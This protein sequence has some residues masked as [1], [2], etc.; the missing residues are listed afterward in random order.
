MKPSASPPSTASTPARRTVVRYLSLVMFVTLAAASLTA[1]MISRRTIRDQEQRV[2]AIRADEVAG[3]VTSSQTGLAGT[4]KLLGGVYLTRPDSPASF[5]TLAKSLVQNDVKYVGIAETQGTS[6]VVRTIVGSGPVVNDVLAGERAEI[7]MRA[8]TEQNMT[9]VLLPTAIETTKTMFRAVGLP[10]RTVIFYEATIDQTRPAPAGPGS[11]LQELDTVVYASPTANSATV[12][13][14]TTGGRTLT[15][16]VDA[17][18]VVVGTDTWLMVT[19]PKQPLTGTF[20]PK[21]PWIILGVGLFTALLAS[22]VVEVLARRRS[23]A[24]NLID[25]RT[26][27]L[28]MTHDELVAARVT[29]DD[30]NRSKS[31]FLSRMSHELRTPLNAVL[32]FAQVLE[33]DPLTEGQKEATQHIVKG[34]KH[35]LN[36]I[37]EI[38]DIS[39]I[40]TGNLT[41]ST[42]SVLLR[43]LVQEAVDLMGPLAAQNGIHLIV[44]RTAQNE[45]YALAD[46]QRLKQILLNLLSNAVK[47]N[48]PGGTVTVSCATSPQAP[49]IGINVSDTGPGITDEQRAL[50]FVPFERLGAEHTPI[51]G[52]GIGLALSDRLVQAMGGSLSV[53]STIGRGSTFT[54]DLPTAEGPVERFE[55]LNPTAVPEPV[56]VNHVAPM[57]HD[58]SPR[59]VLYIEDNAANLRLIERVF[60]NRPDIEIVAAIQGRL[61]L[62]IARNNRPSVIL[63]DLHLPDMPGAAVLD[64]L[65]EDPLTA[66]IPVVVVSADANQRQI[67]RLLESGATAYLTKPLDVHKLAETIDE[68]LGNETAGEPVKQL[69]ENADK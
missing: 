17:R 32:G 55:R 66:R 57:R 44:D 60:T 13:L 1:A 36:L 12:V 62:D 29:A 38:L 43:D 39:R 37:N 69:L 58:D 10:A 26:R 25:Q 8:Q 15:G 54:I 41:L 59:T 33:T 48:R 3:L 2:A 21:V 20:A 40:E 61:G 6:M 68:L 49:R 51:E 31:E 5:N 45:A 64:R 4:L 47:Y 7:A 9:Q 14:T 63:L 28:N 23:Y 52:T 18:A 53:E 24:L 42:E 65:R 34:G 11:P 30:A 67:Q 46:R 27:E 19:K 35:L 22:L 50:L 16:S 56:R